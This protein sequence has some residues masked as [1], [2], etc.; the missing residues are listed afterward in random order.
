MIPE[1]DV[2]RVEGETTW[3]KGKGLFRTLGIFQ[4]NHRTASG[5]STYTKRPRHALLFGLVEW[6]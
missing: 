1:V 3:P 2:N 4:K 6:V 5:I